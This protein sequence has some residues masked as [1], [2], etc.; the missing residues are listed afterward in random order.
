MS[1]R[2]LWT[3]VLLSA[4]ALARPCTAQLN[5]R[6][7]IVYNPSI[8]D[9][10]DVA[11]YYASKRGVPPANL[12][13]ISPS[14]S[15]FIYYTE[16]V[17]TVRPAIR[18]CLDAVNRQNIL[19]IVMAYM[20]PFAVITDQSGWALDQ[21]VADIWDQYTTQSFNSVPTA[22]HGYYTNAQNQGN[23]YKPFV[24]FATW[25]TQPR[26]YLLYSVWRID[27]ATPALAKGLVD[28]AMSAESAGGPAG[29]GCFDLLFG[30]PVGANRFGDTPDGLQFSADWDLHR[31][32][33]F[34]SSAGFSV[35][36]DFNASEFGTPP[37]GRCD[38]AALYAGWYSI[39]NYNDA[40][41]WNPGAIG[42]HLDSASA[43]NPRTGTNWSANAIMKGI[44]VTSGSVAEPY[45][46][47]LARPGG[48]FRN[49]LEGANVGDAFL[50]NTHWLK[51]MTLFLG[52][53][54]YTPFAGGRVPFQSPPPVDSIAFSP[55]EVVG[56]FRTATATITLASPAPSGGLTFNLSVSLPSTLT[57]PPSV[58][59]AGGSTRATFQMMSSVVTSSSM[60]IVVA[61]AGTTV[62]VNTLTLIPMLDGVGVTPTTVKG[63]QGVISGV[64]LG[65][66]APLAGIT[67]G[68]SSSNPAVA[69]VPASVTVAAG[70]AGVTFPITTA[71]VGTNTAVTITAS[72]AGATVQATL[73]VTP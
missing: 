31:A 15:T 18:N 65:D 20:T 21:F 47:G 46:A 36:E 40:F 39:N 44:T 68:L 25:R 30:Q 29:L 69:P 70:Q 38:G 16:Y 67:V 3:I 12:C 64:S 60:P 34:A 37:S 23:V 10:V 32:A 4:F 11:N 1:R 53:P 71:T 35:T 50:R 54:L 24:S 9:S 62:L 28:K 66:R 48:V 33:Q 49:L 56:G 8:P 57:L 6:V 2:F 59:V 5:Q 51:W 58:T 72:Y 17:N 42:F 7:L 55:T 43:Y 27:G 14:N 13:A 19:Y 22:V 73:T 41:T 61:N 26:A 63:G 45:L 52:D